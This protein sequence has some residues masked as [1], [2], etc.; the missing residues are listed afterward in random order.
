MKYNAIRAN[1]TSDA[2]KANKAEK[3]AEVYQSNLFR[4]LLITIGVERQDGKA[5]SPKHCP[6]RHC[7]P[8]GDLHLSL[9]TT[10][11]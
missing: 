4:L 9:K 8:F 1:N 6:S 3:E 2:D 5:I 7:P 11:A 10:I